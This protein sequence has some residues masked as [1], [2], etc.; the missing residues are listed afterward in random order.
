MFRVILNTGQATTVAD[1]VNWFRNSSEQIFEVDG[2][3]GTGKSVVLYEIA[4][5]CGLKP[6]EIMPMAYT[7][8][9]AL[10]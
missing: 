10:S 3:A 1:G 2:E 7:G 6:F 9:A 5:Q 4:R 8:Q